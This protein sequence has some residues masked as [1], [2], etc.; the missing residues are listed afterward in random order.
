[1]TS[2]WNAIYTTGIQVLGEKRDRHSTSPLSSD[3]IMKGLIW[4]ESKS[5]E[6]DK[7]L[8]GKLYKKYPSTRGKERYT[9]N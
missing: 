2:T 6:D 9:S 5:F 7:Y 4:I 8:K 1:M 3:L